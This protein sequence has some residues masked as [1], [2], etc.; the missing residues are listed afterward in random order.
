ML[1]ASAATAGNITSLLTSARSAYT[2]TCS[3]AQSVTVTLWMGLG[4]GLAIRTISVAAIEEGT[5]TSGS[6]WLA[7]CLLAGCW[8]AGCW[9]RCCAAALR[10]D[11]LLMAGAGLLTSTVATVPIRK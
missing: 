9:L 2:V 1:S 10:T 11:R 7:G 3:Q 6:C 4:L 5:D 8:L